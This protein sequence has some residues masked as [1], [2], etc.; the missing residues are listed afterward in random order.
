MG[1]MVMQMMIMMV[2]CYD[3]QL[4]AEHGRGYGDI[5]KIVRVFNDEHGV[6]SESHVVHDDASW[7]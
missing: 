3:G 4:D 7:I 1:V 5:I 6:Q 2:G